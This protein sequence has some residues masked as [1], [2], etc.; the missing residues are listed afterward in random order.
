MWANSS[1]QGNKTYKLTVSVTKGTVSGTQYRCVVKD[2]TGHTK[3]SQ[4]ATLTVREAQNSNNQSD[5]VA[6]GT[7]GTRLKWTLDKRSAL[8]ISGSGKMDDYEE[9]K[10]PWHAYKASIKSVVIQSGVTSVGNNAF[11][12]YYDLVSI[13]IP[14][15]VTRIG[16]YAFWCTVIK[17]ITVSGNVTSI[18]K[19]AFIACRQM[20][21]IKVAGNNKYYTSPDGILYDK[22]Q[23]TLITYPAGRTRAVSVLKGVKIIGYAAFRDCKQLMNVKL[24]DTVE[25]VE[26]GAFWNCNQMERINIPLSMKTIKQYGFAYCSSLEDIHYAG[27]STQWK[28]ISIDNNSDLDKAQVH[29][30]IQK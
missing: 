20:T 3:T 15:S 18:G 1:R 10:Q 21:S 26:E 22:K 19:G 8:I 6:S 9:G 17:T 5:V 24:S 30:Q 27:T 7:C 29:Y 28:K 4:A 12:D 16:E 13:S 23:E 11:C 25:V 14:D 2:S